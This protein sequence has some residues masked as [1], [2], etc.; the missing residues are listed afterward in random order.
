MPPPK[1][2]ELLSLIQR[3]ALV[4]E[5]Q[6]A[7]IAGDV[8]ESA[9][10]EE[11]CA[12]FIDAGLLSKWQCERLCENKWKGFFLGR[13]K[14]IYPLGAGAMGSVFLAEHR[15]M[16]HKVA[17]KVLA[18]RLV[19]RASNVARFE[20][21]ARA[22]AAISHPNVVR[23][24]DIDRHDDVPYLVME[25]VQG[26]DLQKFVTKNGPLEP[27]VAA[28]YTRQIAS[29][30]AEAHRAG[31]IH[32]D[33]KPSN[34][35]L[36]PSGVVKILDLGLA[37]IIDDGAPSLT[38]MNDSKII[39]TVDYLSPEQAINSH[40]IDG[41]ADVYSLGCTLYFL[42]TGSPP[43]P[44]GSLPERIIKHQTRRPVDIRKR[45]PGVPDE[46][47][48]IAG[49]MMEKSAA[50]RVSASEAAESLQSW[51]GGSYRSSQTTPQSVGDRSR[52]EDSLLP[53]D[54]ES[55]LGRPETP[56]VTSRAQESTGGNRARVTSRAQSPGSVLDDLDLA[57][58][59]G[60][61]LAKIGAKEDRSSKQ[62]ASTRPMTPAA[63][64]ADAGGSMLDLA[65]VAPAYGGSIAELFDDVISNVIQT[66]AASASGNSLP[67]VAS[68]SSVPTA[69]LP[70]SG[71]GSLVAP[72]SQPAP[73]TN[74]SARTLPSGSPSRGPN[75]ESDNEINY[76]L[77]AL[78]GF[79]LLLGCVFVGIAVSYSSN[80][81]K[82][83][84]KIEEN[85]IE[86]P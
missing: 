14:L 57:P 22:A 75:T 39:G 38:L 34:V 86:N 36:D 45:R 56:T 84:Q 31:L 73:L 15:V 63:V 23:A 58:D 46:L 85:N 68:S 25:Y 9:T 70:A 79:G 47:V 81:G 1:R 13:Y 28:E 60:E 21:E 48:E 42:L 19:T 40:S 54:E 72:I 16:K 78:I 30:L 18:K 29:G 12:R 32:R 59:E 7:K 41:K 2:E 53:M 69:T 62:V 55:M 52:D 66:A 5:N 24:F 51:L 44:S 3:S 11:V 61:S 6:Y 26:E 35:L 67:T 17:I 71:V 4:D 65:P 33:I 83:N 77:W 50:V 20:R 64:D 8:P 43:F 49:R 74:A 27:R 80:F 82:T 37:R 76:P 10:I